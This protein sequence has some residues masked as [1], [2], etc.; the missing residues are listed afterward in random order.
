M[1]RRPLMAHAS[2]L[3][4]DGDAEGASAIVCLL[5]E[6]A[7]EKPSELLRLQCPAILPEMVKLIQYWSRRSRV[8]TSTAVIFLEMLPKMVSILNILALCGGAE[9]CRTLHKANLTA[10]LLELVAD[11]SQVQ[12]MHQPTDSRLGSADMYQGHEAVVNSALALLTCM[13]SQVRKWK[14]SY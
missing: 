12:H 8:P 13:T 5:R 10:A 7:L 9:F 2:R 4:C 1:R 6:L 14:H 11:H 3:M